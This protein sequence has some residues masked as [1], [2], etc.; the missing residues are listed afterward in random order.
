LSKKW[1]EQKERSN[2]FTLKLI[3]WTALNT[4]RGFVRLLLYPISLYF[5][6]T[7]P[8][9]RKASRQYQR[10]VSGKNVSFWSVIKHIYWFSATILDRVYFLTNQDEKFQININNKKLLDQQVDNK[11]GCILLGSHVGSFEVLRSLAIS[12]MAL[13]V[14][15][16]MNQEHNK[17]ITNILEAL[18]PKVAE[19][20]INLN[21]Q[22]ALFKMK[23]C[24]ENGDIVGVLGDRVSEGEKAIRCEFFGDPA[25]F[26]VSPMRL[27]AVLQVPVILFFGLYRGGN[28]YDIYFEK[29]TDRFNTD[30]ESR[31]MEINQLTNRYI[32]RIEYYLKLAPYN[33]FN[34]YDFW[35]DEA[36]K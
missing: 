35:E 9:T 33:W 24:I 7:S 21:D 19:A 10:R 20:V 26:P 30:R 25:D 11:I 17:M 29:L 16:L 13:P 2:S 14:K 3:C 12:K 31:N 5:F 18:N 27:A 1:I 8:R 22:N 15:I 23:E 4:S 6:L 36:K 32:K 28:C 34:F